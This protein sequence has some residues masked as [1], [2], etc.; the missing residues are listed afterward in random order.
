MPQ[1]VP[2]LSID[3]QAPPVA[4]AYKFMGLFVCAGRK[5]QRQRVLAILYN[6]DNPATDPVTS[7]VHFT[8]TAKSPVLVWDVSFTL[9]AATNYVFV[10]HTCEPNRPELSAVWSFKTP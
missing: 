3:T 1:H 8:L 10:V 9:A 6:R 5:T 2:L 4:G 7:H